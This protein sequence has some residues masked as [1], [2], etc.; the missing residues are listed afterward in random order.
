MESVSV[1]VCVET[2]TEIVEWEKAT[3]D[4]GRKE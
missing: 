1:C 4:G 3:Q 2:K